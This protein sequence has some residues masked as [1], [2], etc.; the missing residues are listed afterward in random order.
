MK[1]AIFL[2]PGQGS[3]TVGMGQELLAAY[4]EAQAVLNAADAA[5][6]KP[7]SPVIVNGP[8]ETLTQSPN[9][10]PAITAINLAILAILHAK[11]IRPVATAGH[12]LGEYSAYAAAGVFD[13]STAVRLT[14]ARGTLMQACA[15]A[16]PGSMVAVMGLDP[17]AIDTICEKITAESGL[18]VSVA[19]YNNA[20]QIVITG[21]TAAVEQASQACQD[22]GAKRCV[23]LPVSGP[24][25]SMLMKDAEVAFSAVLQDT[26]MTD[27]TCPVF[28]N[29]DA[30]EKKNVAEV[31]DALT[32]QI[33]GSVRWMQTMAVMRQ[34]WPEAVF[35]EVG[36]GKV[37]RG[38]MRR[39]DKNAV[40]VNIEDVSSL[41]SALG[42]LADA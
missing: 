8:M 23:S 18:S 1:D 5:L 36:P 19:N 7:I 2:F 28:A 35:V 26:I 42:A 15:D 40:C 17:E 25:H 20:E 21:E 33:C 30:S 29:I 22:A 38:L 14:R 11:G 27:P 6:E 37:L 24:W 10:Q 34:R 31:K 3:Q 39:I 16:H 13:A 9:A 4:P 32:R 12:S 41:E